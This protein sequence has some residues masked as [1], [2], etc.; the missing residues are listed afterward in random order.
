[1]PHKWSPDNSE[2]DVILGICKKSNTVP[3]ALSRIKEH[4]PWA[5]QDSIVNLLRRRGHQSLKWLVGK[6]R[7]S[8]IPDTDEDVTPGADSSEESDGDPITMRSQRFPTVAPAIQ[9]EPDRFWVDQED[10]EDFSPIVSPESDW[11]SRRVLL[12]PDT[13][14]PYHSRRAF[15]L[16][17]KAACEIVRPDTVVV[18]GDFGDFYAASQHDK[19]PKRINRL[20]E[21]LDDVGRGLDVLDSL[22]G[23]RRKLYCAGN[24][25]WRQARYIHTRAPNLDGLVVSWE[26]YLKIDERGW[27]MI[28]YKRIGVV[29]NL[30]VTHETGIGG[31]YAPK[32]VLDLAA[33]MGATDIAFG[34]THRLGMA[35]L[36][37]INGRPRMGISCGW[38]GS[39]KS[40]DYVHAI[41]A[42][43]H[44]NHGFGYAIADDTGHLVPGLGYI[45][46]NR[47]HVLGQTVILPNT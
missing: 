33:G 14:R 27:E 1:M 24:H 28:P 13:H 8:D 26:E 25:E 3:E 22:P 18:L 29:G 15:N 21:E 32:R 16:M 6:K 9:E 7:I 31:V 47:A 10:P 42:F 39:H 23:V 35:M 46:G 30:L 41:Q 36:G 38:L 4:F 2:V 37:S 19:D 44:Y 5:T 40:A 11:Q 45:Y 12:V 20:K 43:S 17:L 34:H